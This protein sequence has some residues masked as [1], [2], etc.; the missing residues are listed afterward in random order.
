MTFSSF[1]ILLFLLAGLLLG[2]SVFPKKLLKAN[3][4]LLTAG[5][6]LV[7]FCM[8]VSL[9]SSPTLGADL[10]QAGV[11]ALVLSVAAVAGSVAAVWLLAKLFKG[12]RG[13]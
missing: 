3:N 10:A 2:L 8:G 7:L 1:C 5:I 4:L 13:E 6:A 9:G 12:G 11:S